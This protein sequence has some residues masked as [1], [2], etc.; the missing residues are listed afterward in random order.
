MGKRDRFWA[1]LNVEKRSQKVLNLHKF[2]F[3]LK[4][5]FTELVLVGEE[6]KKR[7]PPILNQLTLF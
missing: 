7:C 4:V 6:K 3:S 2:L 5:S 1:M